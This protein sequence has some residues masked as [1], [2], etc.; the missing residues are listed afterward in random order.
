VSVDEVF[1]IK[2]SK[3]RCLF[4]SLLIFSWATLYDFITGGKENQGRKE[5]FEKYLTKNT[6]ENLVFNYT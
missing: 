4:S 1:K 6:F 3:Y 2:K 5:K